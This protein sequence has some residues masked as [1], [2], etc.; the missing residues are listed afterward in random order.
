MR[1]SIREQLGCLILLCVLVSLSVLSIA[2]WCTNY[3][4]VLHV[5]GTRLH[6]AASLKAAQIA[7]NLEMMRIVGTTIISRQVIRNALASYN[8]A[9]ATSFGFSD[10]QTDILQALDDASSVQDPLALQARVYSLGGI[11]LFSATS[12]GLNI[13]LPWT[14]S[15]GSQAT[16][17]DP[18]SG[19]APT[20][21]PNITA[22]RVNGTSLGI[23]NGLLME[24][25]STLVLGPLTLNSS[26]SLL[27][28]T[29]P[30]MDT[31][32]AASWVCDHCDGYLAN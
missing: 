30:L 29:L 7:Q 19:Y 32:A 8:N 6:T 25:G 2:V 12:N 26:L 11:P 18:D 28:L 16:L 9:S 21:Y 20:L 27:S 23:A 5:A 4:F 13:D 1:L 31:N 10:A 14:N 3:N 24:A 22:V 15:N 17:A